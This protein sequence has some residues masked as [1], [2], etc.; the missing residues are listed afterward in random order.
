[1]T[2][3]EQG[4]PADIRDQQKDKEPLKLLD[5]YDNAFDIIGKEMDLLVTVDERELN[6]GLKNIYETLEALLKSQSLR[7]SLPEQLQEYFDHDT[8][9]YRQEIL[10]Q[11]GDA[12]ADYLL[13]D[14]KEVIDGRRK[15]DPEEMKYQWY[16][17]KK[18]WEPYRLI[19]QDLC[20]RVGTENN[21]C[22]NPD[23][24]DIDKDKPIDRLLQTLED[25][26]GKYN[27][28]GREMKVINELDQNNVKDMKA[29][30]PHGSIFNFI[31]NCV[32][33][34]AHDKI[35]ASN[36]L[37]T[38]KQEG[39]NLVF[40]I[41]DNG[42]GMDQTTQSKIF[43]EGYTTK[44]GKGLGLANAQERF[45]KVGGEVEVESKPNYQPGQGESVT[46]FILKIPLVN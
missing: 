24:E 35:G 25:L 45:S 42:K 44:R 15:L 12:V 21:R 27:K 33:N 4:V 3:R 23:H 38:I 2:E 13:R 30:V 10:G 18:N 6:D 7:D 17:I 20:L 9:A 39:S 19:V 34:G 28:K 26:P 36:I 29:Q 1:M 16:L 37:L 43:D 41:T 8:L 40:L 46:K 14:L 31:Q 32:S 11:D 22:I 5:E